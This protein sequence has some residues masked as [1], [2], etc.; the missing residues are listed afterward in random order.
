MDDDEK[1]RWEKVL[2]SFNLGSS[3]MYPTAEETQS[4][5]NSLLNGDGFQVFK[6]PETSMF[7]RIYFAAFQRERGFLVDAPRDVRDAYAEHDLL[8]IPP[9]D[10]NEYFR[11]GLTNDKHV[12]DEGTEILE[13]ILAEEQE[14]LDYVKEKARPGNETSEILIDIYNR[15]QESVRRLTELVSTFECL[16]RSAVKL[17]YCFS[18]QFLDPRASSSFKNPYSFEH[19]SSYEEVGG[20][21]YPL[22]DELRRSENLVVKTSS[23]FMEKWQGTSLYSGFFS[24]AIAM[25]NDSFGSEKAEEFKGVVAKFYRMT[26][27]SLKNLSEDFFKDVRFPEKF[28]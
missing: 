24:T 25:N 21:N 18:P 6:A 23:V 15:E 16:K 4:T 2:S 13:R 8:A 22:L 1:Q 11:D 9:E 14:Y 26:S 7:R 10:Q 5:L 19:G 17:A 3:L 27:S 28:R 20:T 12:F